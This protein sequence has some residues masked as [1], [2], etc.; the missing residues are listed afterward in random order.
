MSQAGPSFLLFG[1][2]FTFAKLLG[3]VLSLL[4][5]ISPNA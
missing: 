5:V 2:V 1:F 4:N 3:T